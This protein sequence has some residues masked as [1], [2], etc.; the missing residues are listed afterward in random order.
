M[1][2]VWRH[3]PVE[4]SQRLL[5]LAIADNANDE[6]VAWPST[7]TLAGKACMTVR[8]VS[9]TLEALVIAGWLEVLPRSFERRGNTYKLNVAKL[10]LSEDKMSSDEHSP[11]NLSRDATGHSQPSDRTFQTPR[12]D[13]LDNP[14]HPPIGRTT[15][16]HQEPSILEA[17]LSAL[18]GLR[19]SPPRRPVTAQDYVNYWN[20][21]CGPLP[22]V[23]EF[24]KTQERQLKARI[25]DDR[26]TPTKWKKAIVVALASPRCCGDN[27]DGWFVTFDFLIADAANIAKILNGNYGTIKPKQK[28]VLMDGTTS[29]S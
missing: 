24:T 20:S 29:W 16:N 10:K 3:G 13:I 1:S 22:K 23:D 2:A 19:Q 27:K 4:R 14:P 5:L 9:R 17:P 25:R 7:Q 12:Q 26:L 8:T 11:D 15:S 18:N 28:H 6:A 21:N